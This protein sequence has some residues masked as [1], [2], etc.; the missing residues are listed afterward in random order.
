MERTPS[1]PPSESSRSPP[2]VTKIFC[3]LYTGILDA[4]TAINEGQFQLDFHVVIAGSNGYVSSTAHIIP[5]GFQRPEPFGAA[6]IVAPELCADSYLGL[7]TFTASGG[8]ENNV[9]AVRRCA[10][11]C[12]AQN[13]NNDNGTTQEASPAIPPTIRAAA[14]EPRSPSLC[15]FFN[16]YMLYN[17]SASM[18]MW[19]CAMYTDAWTGTHA[20]N[21]G[22]FRGSDQISIGESWGYRKVDAVERS[23]EQCPPSAAR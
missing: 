18:G 11:A 3:A 17:N 8:G 22:Q 2:A 20:T 14:V 5:T 13:S 23:G 9:T 6:A 15:T 7:R 19:Q 12:A 21:R 16:T 1:S 4:S 10:A